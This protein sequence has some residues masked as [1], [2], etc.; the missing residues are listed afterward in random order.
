MVKELSKSGIFIDGYRICPYSSKKYVKKHPNFKFKKNMIKEAKCI[1]PRPEMV[2]DIL[3]K[4]GL[5]KSETSI[6][7]IGDRK[8]DVLTGINSGGFGILV[9][10]VNRRG[11]DKKTEKL[12]NKNKYLAKNFIDACKFIIKRETC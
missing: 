2:L 10:F 7:V 1:K 6:Y 12:K 4:A 3:K 11:E 5:K 8:E 9:P